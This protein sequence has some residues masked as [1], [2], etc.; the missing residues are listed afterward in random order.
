MP[1]SVVEYVGIARV[2]LLQA[3]GDSWRIIGIGKLYRQSR[4]LRWRGST[5]FPTSLRIGNAAIGLLKLPYDI[6]EC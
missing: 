1:T 3:A 6:P 4:G 5:V 2:G